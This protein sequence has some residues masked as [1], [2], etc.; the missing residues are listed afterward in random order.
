MFEA[1]RRHQ[2]LLLFV[3][4]ILILPAFVFFGVAGYDRMGSGG[5][6]VASVGGQPISEQEFAE[7]QRRQIDNLRQ[8]LGDAIDVRMFD[9]PEAR[10]EILEGLIAR[11]VIASEANRSNV[12]VTDEQ[13]RDAILAIPGLVGPDGTFD[14]A[15]YRALLSSQ[16]MSAAGFESMLRSDLALQAL[17]E[18]VRASAIVPQTVRDKIIALQEQARTVRELRFAPEAFAA[19][20]QPTP[21]QLA[22]FYE[23]NP[24]LFETPEVA[25]VE[26]VVLDREAL[27]TQ[28]AIGEDDL[29]AHY[30]QNA[31]RWGTPEER[32]ARHILIANGPDA[33]ARAEQLVAQLAAAPDRF[34]ELAKEASADPGS[35]AEGG[36]LGYFD[37]TSMVKPFAD[38]AFAMQPGEIRG[39]VQ[40]EFGLHV[41]QVTDVRP[42]QAKTFE[43]VRPQL[44]AEIRA[45]QAAMLYAEAAESFTNIVYE[46]SDSLKPAADKY[47]LEVRTATL[48]NRQPG[49]ETARGSPI[50][51]PRVV[52]SLFADDT[53][54]NKRNTEAIEV[55]PGTLVSARVVAYNPPTRRPFDEVRDA[56]QRLYVAREAAQLARQAGE[57]RLKALVASPPGAEAQQGF[58]PRFTIRR[59][60]PGDVDPRLVQAVFRVSPDKMPG[61]AGV[62]MGERGYSVV[63]L[64]DVAMPSPEEIEQ[65]REAYTQQ[66]ARV[67]AQQDL[68]AYIDGLKQRAEV[69][70][71]LER[72]NRPDRF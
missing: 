16:N 66:I 36:D 9:T 26:Y 28:V 2:R 48:T 24:R 41:I 47:K 1:I 59:T 60:A 37:R 54:K 68:S 46:Q 22:Q 34:P 3:L 45:Q 71:N 62:D 5:R 17:P 10:A 58:G 50:A 30:Q 72:L 11:R 40:T 31:A 7:A 29:R 20:V 43:E 57:E 38:A 61:Y 65:R 67:V 4:V 18:A 15:R 21:E 12:V 44:E 23:Q 70:R 14:D 52:G 33:K 69:V 51:S 25:Q 35:A 13:V 27:A 6:G 64:V 19:S 32:R 49:P 55:A 56:V 63:E 42:A 53:L 8:M 39:P